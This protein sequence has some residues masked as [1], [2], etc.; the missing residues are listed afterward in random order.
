M[1]VF[2]VAVSRDVKQPM[3]DYA[4]SGAFSFRLLRARIGRDKPGRTS[5]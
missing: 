5:A 1:M 4:I 3:I 2:M